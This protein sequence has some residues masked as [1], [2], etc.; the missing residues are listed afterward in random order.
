M[1]EHI[2]RS[3]RDRIADEIRAALATG[4]KTSA[5]ILETSNHAHD[6]TEVGRVIYALRKAGTVK[7][8]GFTADSR[9]QRIW[10]WTG[11][12]AVPSFHRVDAE[13]KAKTP[14]VPRKASPKQGD[15]PTM[16]NVKKP[17]DQ[18][19][20]TEPKEPVRYALPDPVETALADL[21]DQADETTLAYADSLLSGNAVWTRLRALAT[22]AHGA[23]CDYR[24]MRTLEAK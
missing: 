14:K 17:V 13:R 18:P 1:N 15:T 7:Q 20:P 11:P 22:D 19:A 6:T 2:E 12:D 5:Q 24:L 8:A 9:H 21:L 23:L 10:T 4:D 3:V 16:N